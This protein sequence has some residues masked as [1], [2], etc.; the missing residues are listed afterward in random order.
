MTT[1]VQGTNTR[2]AHLARSGKID[3]GRRL[4]ILPFPA[5]VQ[6]GTLQR[7]QSR[8]RRTDLGGTWDFVGTN[9]SPVPY[10]GRNYSRLEAIAFPTVPALSAFRAQAAFKANPAI[11]TQTVA[12]RVAGELAMLNASEYAKEFVAAYYL[13]GEARLMKNRL[14]LLA[15]VRYEG[16]DIDGQ[17]LLN[18]PSLVFVRNADGTFARTP[19]GARIRKPEAG[20]AGSLEETRFV[21]QERGYTAERTYDGYYPSMHLSY[22]VTDDFVARLAYARTYGRP[23]FSDI[24]PNASINEAD[25]DADQLDDPDIIKGTITVRNTGLKP[26]TA[27]N[28]DLSM[29]YYTK[30]GG[31]FSAGA[32]LKEITDFFGT[33]V[34]LATPA[35]LEEVG[36]EPRYVGW[37][38]NTTFNSGDARIS[39]IEFNARQSL[40]QLG[41]W[42]RYFTVFAN[43][44][45]LKL[46]GNPFATFTAFVPKSATWGFSYNW[47]RVTVVPKWTYRGLVKGAAQPALG[48]DTFQYT[49]AFTIMDLNVVYRLK[50]EL[51]LTFS[52]NNVFNAFNAGLMRYGSETPAYAY[53]T[54]VGE[55]G[56]AFSIGVKGK[57]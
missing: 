47:R 11:L 22:N 35:I 1:A 29:E 48:P 14:K 12:Q 5:T 21:L 38:V 30:Q 17:G 32:F 44:T 4:E 9:H 31:M 33:S 52:I 51:A 50:G 28:Y 15:G 42:G 41:G 7:I 20:A 40:R 25:L 2:N 46:E 8:D 24:I 37:N 13:Q 45:R 3:L 39:G 19:A 55:Y 18:D 10:L 6:I 53:A 16:T 26:W 54:Q 43:A 57:F 56:P 49:R 34:R 23:N 36:L 27:H